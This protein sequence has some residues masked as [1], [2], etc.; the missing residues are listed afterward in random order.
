MKLL[1]AIDGHYVQDNV[2]E[3]LCI[4]IQLN[5]RSYLNTEPIHP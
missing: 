3:D 2:K 4:T 5:A 1:F